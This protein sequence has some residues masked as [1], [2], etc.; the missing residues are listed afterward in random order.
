LKAWDLLSADGIR[1]GLA[2]EY[3]GRNVVYLP[4]TGST[5]VEARRLAER[6]VPEGTLVIAD[7]QTAGRGRLQ[8][9]WE[10]PPGSSLLMSL[11]FRP[12]LAPFQVQRLTMICGL[13]VVDA[14]ESETGLRV[15]LKWPNDLV[16]CG[17]KVGG[18]LTEVAMAGDRVDWAIVGIGLNVNV[19]FAQQPGDFLMAPTS[20]SQA[21]ERPVARLPLLKVLLCILE[22][23][24]EA[25]KAGHSFHNEW[26]ERLV[27]LG[28]PVTVST[29]DT[30]W[31][32]TAEGVD[33]DGALLVRLADGRLQVVVA[34]DVTLRPAG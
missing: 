11:I 33:A 26:A 12:P 22:R 7:H 18:I 21:L 31:E 14:V 15:D 6:G 32:G 5:N 10:A 24:Y 25:L 4:E 1:D 16:L 28:K 17:A 19:N 13:A 9:R 34:G 8:R 29:S 3:V 23:R 20:L 27:T 2:T 30:V